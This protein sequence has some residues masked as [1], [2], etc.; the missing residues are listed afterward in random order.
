[1]SD[2]QRLL[3]DIKKAVDRDGKDVWKFERVSDTDAEAFTRRRDPNAVTNAK[4][5]EVI[6]MKGA[7]GGQRMYA[8]LGIFVLA[9]GSGEPSSDAYEHVKES[10]L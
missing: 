4:P 6:F 3:S 8:Y 10:Y 2:F 5:L 9:V 7:T 1:M